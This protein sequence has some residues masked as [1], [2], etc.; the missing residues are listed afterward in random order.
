MKRSKRRSPCPVACTL[1]LVGDRWTL[2]VLRD[3]W[4][5]KAHFHEF[6]RSPERIASNILADRLEWLTDAGLIASEPSDQRAGAA[7]YKLTNKGR[8]LMPVLEA[9]RDWG[10]ANI[11]GTQARIAPA[12][13]AR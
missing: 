9:L 13:P 5:G 8:S 12:S 10:L 11:P 1:D 7:R 6:M 4:A 2:L 3:L